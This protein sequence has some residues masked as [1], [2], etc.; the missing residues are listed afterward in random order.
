MFRDR[1]QYFKLCIPSGF[2]YLEHSILYAKRVIHLE[3][4]LTERNLGHGDLNVTGG[5]AIFL[6]Y[7]C[8][9]KR[10]S[11][12]ISKWRHPPENKFNYKLRESN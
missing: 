9:R 10:S 11:I 4:G 5:K 3:K 8:T 1:W 7:N 6:W 2:K 12:P